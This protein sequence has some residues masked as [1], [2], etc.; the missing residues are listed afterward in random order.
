M[1][2]TMWCDR[3]VIV[4]MGLCRVVKSDAGVWGG[5]GWDVDVVSGCDQGIDIETVKMA[6]IGR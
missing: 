6:N 4:C 2:W 1:V 5:R 3:G